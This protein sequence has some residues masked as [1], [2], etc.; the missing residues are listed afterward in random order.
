MPATQEPES[1]NKHYIIKENDIIIAGICANIYI[2]KIMCV[3]LLFVDEA[4]R[5]KNLG[6]VLLQRVE[7]EVKSMGAKLVHLDTF[8]FQAKGFYLKQG[9]AVFGVLD[10][11]PQGHKRY[12]LKKS[13]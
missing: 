12:Y 1:I 8:D 3:E 11:Y 13:L 7:E 2:W 10:N 9:Y 5:N 6:T 4:Y